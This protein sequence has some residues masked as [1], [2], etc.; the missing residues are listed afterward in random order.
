MKKI[1]LTALEDVKEIQQKFMASITPYGLTV[2][3]HFWKDDLVKWSWA[4]PRNALSDLDVALWVILGSA[5]RLSS[6]D[7]RY[8]LSLLTLSV[9]AARGAGFPVVVVQTTD[10]AITPESLPTPLKGAEI[11][12]LKSPSLGPKLTAKI[13]APV[14][15]IVTDYRVDILGNEH[16]G[17]WFELGPV[18]GLWRGGLFGVSGGEILF[19]AVGNRGGLPKSAELHYPSKGMKIALGETEY[20]AWGV[21]NEIEAASSYYVKVMGAPESVL[22]GPYPMDESA[23]LYVIRLK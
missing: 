4:G 19:Q 2:E 6:P 20:L 3:G 7:T 12:P 23:D 13:H 21:Q 16:L 10:V 1:W 17:Q 8:G 15:K 9:Q 11:L 14:K 22:F 5:E 18:D